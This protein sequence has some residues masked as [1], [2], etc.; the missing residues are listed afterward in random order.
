MC[1]L[2]KGP[3]LGSLSFPQVL[4]LCLKL[5]QFEQDFLYP[6]LIEKSSNCFP[7]LTNQKLHRLAKGY[8][9]RLFVLRNCFFYLQSKTDI[10]TN[11]NLDFLNSKTLCWDPSK[12]SFLDLTNLNSLDLVSCFSKI[13]NLK[14]NT[15]YPYLYNRALLSR[16][17]QLAK[18]F[19]SVNILIDR[20]NRLLS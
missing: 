13:K 7:S 17:Y 20:N 18:I 9:I 10:I 2:Q 14:S 6:L 12:D 4:L 19:F 11:S 5:E 3:L 8:R 15:L 16:E 1:S